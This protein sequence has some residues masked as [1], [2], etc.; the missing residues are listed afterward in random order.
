MSNLILNL[1]FASQTYNV[2][3]YC[4]SGTVQMNV[5]EQ[6]SPMVLFIALYKVVLTFEFVDKIFK[7]C[8]SV[9]SCASRV[10]SEIFTVDVEL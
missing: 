3:M 7:D 10:W 2:F 1:S 5:T 9:C 4:L 6:H 8:A